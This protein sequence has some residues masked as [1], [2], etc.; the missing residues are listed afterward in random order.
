MQIAVFLSFSCLF[1]GECAF[2]EVR[3]I[4][5]RNRRVLLSTDPPEEI[6]IMFVFLNIIAERLIGEIVS[7]KYHISI[8]H[9]R[10]T[11]KYVVSITAARALFVYPLTFVLNLR[12]R[13]RIPRSY[14]HMLLFAGLRGAMAFA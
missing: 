9:Y 8:V 5:L 2:C 4:G 3:G 1:G 12:R 6:T 7:V 13:P 11:F 10:M 14:Q